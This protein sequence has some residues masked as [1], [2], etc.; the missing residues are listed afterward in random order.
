MNIHKFKTAWNRNLE[1]SKRKGEEEE[2][3]KDTED[4]AVIRVTFIEHYL[5][6]WTMF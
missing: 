1:N 6:R 4:R 2:L 3:T 5:L